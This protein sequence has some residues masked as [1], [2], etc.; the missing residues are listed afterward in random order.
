[1]RNDPPAGLDPAK[2]DQV[3][4]MAQTMARFNAISA[5]IMYA[6]MT[7]IGAGLLFAACA[8]L[9]VSVRFPALFTLVA[10][11]GLINVMQMLAH[12]FVLRGKGELSSMKELVPSFGLEIFLSE[13][14]PKLLAGLLSFFSI[15]TLWHIVMLA[16]GVAALAQISKGKAFLVTSPNWM[17]GLVFAM[18]ASLLR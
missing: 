3:I 4:G 18:I 17:L 12:Y 13:D 2:L 5:P 7:L 1:M 8:V 9:S 16:V 14:A 15:F 11:I 10:H 6:V